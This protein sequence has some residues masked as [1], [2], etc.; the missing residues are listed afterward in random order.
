MEQFSSSVGGLSSIMQGFYVACILLSAS[1]SSLASGHIAD[2]I[3]RKY[4]IIGGGLVT[5]AGTVISAACSSIGALFGA[6]II[7]G[8]G[9]GTAMSIATVYLVEISPPATRG[10]L[11]GLLQLFITIGVAVGYFIAFGSRTI[12]SSLAWR[13]PFIC[14]SAA[15]LFLCVGTFFIPFSPRWL[16][17]IERSEDARNVLIRLR[18]SAVA[19][20]ELREIEESIALGAQECGSFMEMFDRRY[21]RRTLLGIFMMV[22]LQMNGVRTFHT[23]PFD[24]VISQDQHLTVPR[25]LMLFSTLPRSFLFKLALLQ[26]E[27]HF[28][29]RE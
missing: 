26:S 25:R 7:T 29:R 22:C 13:V 14:Q 16:A 15:A 2:R 6:R 3:S 18:G 17:Q 5:M 10:S 27:H 8:A 1:F 20:Q 23:L 4:T 19:E 11:A 21:R 28:S 9:I 24:N 12:Q